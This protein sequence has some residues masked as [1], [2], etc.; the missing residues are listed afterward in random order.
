M[1]LKESELL[2]ACFTLRLAL[3][4]A[5]VLGVRQRA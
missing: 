1:F 5:L 2:A 3:K 4:L